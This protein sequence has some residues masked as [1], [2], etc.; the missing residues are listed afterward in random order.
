MAIDRQESPYRRGN[1]YR[2][3]PIPMIEDHCIAVGAGAVQLV[4]ESRTLTNE[5]IAAAVP[6]AVAANVPFDDFGATLHVCGT[7]DGLEHLRFD[8]FENEPHYHYIEQA[9]SANTVV[10]IDELAVGDPVEFSLS[11]VEHHLPDM[12]RNCGVAELAGEV[13][14]QQELVTAAMAEVRELMTKARTRGRDD[15]APHRSDARS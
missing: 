9:A 8:C 6:D 7:V 5:I 4:V 2:Q 12:L 15:A 14:G 10:R 1:R 13:A 11:C 3:L